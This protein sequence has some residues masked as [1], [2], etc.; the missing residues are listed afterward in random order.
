MWTVVALQT[1]RQVGEGGEGVS[2]GRG[3]M[4]QSG[5]TEP[6]QLLRSLQTWD[7]EQAASPRTEPVN[8]GGDR[9]GIGAAGHEDAVGASVE[10]RLA[11]PEG[12]L[13]QRR[14]W[15]VLRLHSGVGEHPEQ[16]S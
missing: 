13:E 4:G 12:L 7:G 9:L 1:G 15:L 3:A 8:E 16:S 6:E 11:A 14:W 10:E 5:D 2:V